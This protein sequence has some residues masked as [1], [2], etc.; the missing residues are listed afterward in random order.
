MSIHIHLQTERKRERKGSPGAAGR[1]RT[2][3]SPEAGLG[4]LMAHGPGQASEVSERLRA[5]V[6]WMTEILQ[7]LG[8]PREPCR[9]LIQEYC[10]NYRDP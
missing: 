9:G 10:L 7:H 6:L 1:A 4:D 5:D 8:I 3:A 2:P